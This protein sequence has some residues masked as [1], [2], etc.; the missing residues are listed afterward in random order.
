MGRDK[1]G[2]YVN[3][4]GVTIKVDQ[5]KNGKDHVSFYDGPVDGDHSAVHVNVDY[6]NEQWTSTTHGENHS[7]TEKGSGGCY[8]TSACMKKY[9]EQF[10][11]NCYE[12][13]LL[14]WFRDKF[15]SKEDIEHYYYYCVAP[16]IVSQIDKLNNSNEIYKRIYENVICVCVKAIEDK[17]YD[18]AYNIYK[19]NV[20]DLEKMY[21]SLA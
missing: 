9:A 17:K 18:V 15:V 7:D 12:L 19:Q 11:D 8:L 16:N 6:D 10:D 2:N 13:N 20:L 3:E 4:K 21:I 5:D 14:R 1:Y